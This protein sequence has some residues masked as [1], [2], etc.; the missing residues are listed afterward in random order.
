[1]GVSGDLETMPLAEVLQWAGAHGKSGL[2]E[3]ER[4]KLITRIRFHEGRIVGCSSTDPSSLLGHYLISR[5]KI[6]ER[7]LNFALTQQKE[8]GETLPEILLEIG[9][10]S[11]DELHSLVRAK[12]EESIY[13]LFDLENASF[14]F[15]TDAPTDHY[16]V[17]IS[18]SVE[19]TLLEGERHQDD[20]RQFR[21]V[22]DSISLVLRRSERPLNA[23]P[24][25]SALGLQLLDLCANDRALAEILLRAH[26][27]EYEVLKTLYEFYQGGNIE[28]VGRAPM[29]RD[30]SPLLEDDG[31][32]FP[33]D[34]GQATVDPEEEETSVLC[35]DHAEPERTDGDAGESGS[36]EV[37]IADPYALVRIVSEKFDNGD[38][39]GALA[40]LDSCY[41]TRNHDNLLQQLLDRA[42]EAYLSKVRGESLQ[43]DR[44]PVRTSAPEQLSSTELDPSESA[45]MGLI[46]GETNIQSILWIMPLHE[47][48][49]LRS[50]ERL[51][52]RG[53]IRLE[54]PPTAPA[55]LHQPTAEE[56]R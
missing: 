45:L 12:S 54:D 4:D 18:L 34:H 56:V 50:L 8:T 35:T 49:I 32:P 47:I 15:R 27:S 5:G 44:I 3:I 11:I 55:G 13:R 42:E 48:Q 23:G 28:I 24:G 16:R 6:T 43:P 2:L 21:E 19:E 17:E 51:R 36:T 41:R 30:P 46:D 33:S 7:T 26:A 40:I 20:M 38:E 22:F 52:T 31:I 53:L 25:V 9:V 37:Q 1:M 10:L 29:T 39:E 14:R